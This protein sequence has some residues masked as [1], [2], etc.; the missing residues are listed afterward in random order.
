MMTSFD[1]LKCLFLS[2]SLAST[3]PVMLTESP[4]NI[5]NTSFEKSEMF[6]CQFQAT[7]NDFIT[8][9][10]FINGNPPPKFYTIST[11]NQTDGNM[12]SFTTTLSTY[13]IKS[14]LS[15]E[16][17]CQARKLLTKV[18]KSFQVNVQGKCEY[19]CE[20]QMEGRGE[21]ID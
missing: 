20:E 16:Y 4:P 13:F 7:V 5:V 17:V 15:G 12:M 18:M 2:Y 14:P 1:E 6:L 11:M 21:V 8:I 9:E 10:W 19:S 3:T